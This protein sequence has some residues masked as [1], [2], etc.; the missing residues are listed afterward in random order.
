[1][2]F[3][4]EQEVSIF[5]AKFIAEG[6]LRA[7]LKPMIHGSPGIGKSA[8]ARQIAK[9]NNLKLIDLRLTQ[10]DPADLNGLPN[11]FGDR[12]KFQVFEQF[13][14]VGDELPVNPETKEPFAGWLLFLDE[15]TSADDDRQAAA[16]K[17]ILDR[18]IGNEDLHPKCLVMGAGNLETDGA[19]VNPMSSALISRLHHI[20][21][22]ND[23]K[24]WL[25]VV[26]PKLDIA[27]KVQAFLEFSP[28]AFYTFDP[29]NS[30][31]VYACPRTWEDFSKWFLKVSPEQNPRA[32]DDMLQLAAAM[33]IIG[34]VAADFKSFLAYFGRL[35]S[36]EEI[37]TSPSTIHVPKDEPGLMFAMCSMLAENAKVDNIDKILIFLDRFNPD[38]MVITLRMAC[39]RNKGLIQNPRIS[40][41]VKKNLNMF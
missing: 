29:Q 37:L 21:V 12:A 1:M 28:R 6:F 14:L 36:L 3:P 10:M 8:V 32:L 30:G 35:P 25:Q 31:R 18:Q 13:P 19:I 20:V 41:W 5:D 39:Q 34:T 15:L 16:Y 26:A 23:L 2:H 9:E 40:E 7:G 17:L 27:T 4:Q 33:G 38:H 24:R 11:L 22:R